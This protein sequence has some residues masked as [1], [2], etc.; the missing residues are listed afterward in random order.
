MTKLSRV[1]EHLNEDD[2]RSVLVEELMALERGIL[3]LH[4]GSLRGGP[5]DDSN[6]MI[7]VLGVDESELSVDA[8]IG[9]F[10]HEIIAG[11]SCLDEDTLENAYC[12]IVVSI[13]R[14]SAEVEFRMKAE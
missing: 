8:R 5:I 10:F 4:K 13:N 9:V 7:S 6:L 12:E 2:F 14:D 1:L 3:P 11:G